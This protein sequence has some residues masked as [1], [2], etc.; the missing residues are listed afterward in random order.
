MT[1]SYASAIATEGEQL[2]SDDGEIMLQGGDQ[3]GA[4]EAYY[5][6]REKQGLE[7][8]DRTERDLDEPREIAG[9]VS[10]RP[11]SNV[12]WDGQRSSAK[13]R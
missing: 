13:L 4:G 5:H 1:S 6:G 8:T 3:G 2:S 7:F 12:A 9:R 11:F 10:G